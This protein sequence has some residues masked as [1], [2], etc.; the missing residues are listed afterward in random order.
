MH[1]GEMV[2]T[3]TAGECSPD[4]HL[5]IAALPYP[6]FLYAPDGVVAAANPT[7]ERMAG[8]SLAGFT[9]GR[10]IDALAIRH[11]DGT[12]LAPDELPAARALAG[13]A[14]LACP[15][16]VTSADGNVFAVRASS[17]PLLRG[18]VVVGVLSTWPDVTDLAGALDDEQRRRGEAEEYARRQEAMTETLAKQKEELLVK[19]ARLRRHLDELSC[20]QEALRD[21]EQRVRRTLE[22]LLSPGEEFADLELSDILDLPVLQELVEGFHRL[23]GVPASIIDLHGK[24][25]VGVGWQACCTKFHRVHPE[26]CR[27]CIE[28]D[29]D[30]SAGIAP[31][32]SRLYRCR[33][34]MWDIAT[35]IMLGER[36]VGNVFS[37][38]FFFEDEEPDLHLFR[39]QARRYGFDE[40]AYIAALRAVPRLKRETVEA[41]MAF[42]RRLAGLISSQG[43]SNLRLARALVE[44]D[45]LAASLERNR[46]LLARAQ[47]IAHLG[48]WELDLA[49]NSLSWSDEVYRVFGLSPREF[50]ATY[51]AFLEAV[52]PDDRK[53]VDDA[54]AGSLREGRDTYEI[55][56]RVLR[57][58]TG[59]VRWVHERCEHQR[60]EAGRIVRSIGMV[61]DITT[62]KLAEMELHRK[63]EDLGAQNEELQA[64]EEELRVQAEELGRLNADLAFQR[65]LLDTIFETLPHEI[66]VWEQSGR[67]VWLNRRVARELDRSRDELIGKTWQEIG[68]DPAEMELLMAEVGRVCATGEPSASETVRPYPDGARWQRR[69]V[70]RLPAGDRVVAVS[71]DITEWKDAE[72]A[73]R[74]YAERLRAS[75]E[76]LQ[77]FAYVASH[78]LQEPLRSIVSFSQLLDRRY[79][80]RLDADADDYLGYIVEGGRRMQALILDLL[81]VSRI[82]TDAKPLAPTETG[83]IVAGVVRALETSI[84]EADG[85]VVVDPLPTVL[86]DPSQLELVFTNLI[87]NALKYRRPGIPPVI[88]VS[89][90]REGTL[91]RFTVEDNG[92][93]IDPEYFERIFVMFQRLH[94]REQ[95][96]GTGIGLAIVKKIV[97]RHGGQVWVESS[98]GAGSTFLFTLPAH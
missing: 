69:T 31:G 81:Q 23:S 52:H 3:A 44:R 94:T 53:A 14:V 56:H 4:L 6:V 61:H 60:D 39:A 90:E 41:G 76:E 86:A 71:T 97:E 13:Q 29:L 55:E 48:S 88:R 42:L 68:L 84:S 1:A 49:T 28:S 58:P 25:L 35:P 21:S 45:A 32:E 19:E 62:R 40:A 16:T 66:S 8:T 78:D 73:L 74:N 87:G 46:A 57:R 37:G 38:Q 54:Y 79:R 34:H 2:E 75:N 77:R 98:P 96:D 80:G 85:R 17:S 27:Y 89:A 7:A 70:N 47:E 64:Q 26:T 5:V 33:N 83:A 95:Y 82:E 36:H 30:L 50:R 10:V 43:Y 92:I 22:R 72:Q 59:E 20:S 67:S 11:P 9:V 24:I 63:N 18:G 91:W 12:P 15:L 93:G 65:D 51:E